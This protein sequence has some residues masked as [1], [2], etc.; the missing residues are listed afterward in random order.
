MKLEDIESIFVSI[1]YGKGKAKLDSIILKE[2]VVS[3]P[4]GKGKDM[5]VPIEARVIIDS[6]NSLW[7][8]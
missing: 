7:E 5:G 4:Y 6:I 8:R 1:P 2:D 3:I